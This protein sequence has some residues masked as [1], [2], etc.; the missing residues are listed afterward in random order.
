V[1]RQAKITFV[2]KIKH[3]ETGNKLI[4]SLLVFFLYPL[5]LVFGLLAMC[6]VGLLS[7]WQKLTNSKKELQEAEEMK[8]KITNESKHWSI[9]TMM[10]NVAI[11][12]QLA[13]SLPW[14]SGDYFYLKSSPE[15]EYL[16]NKLFGDWLLVASGGV[17]L[18]RW[19]DTENIN[20]DLAFIDL[21]TLKVTELKTDIPT[22]HWETEK[23]NENEI[24]FTFSTLKA[25]LVYI[26]D[27]T[28][29]LSKS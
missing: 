27:T 28:L 6:F 17:F 11:E 12:K 21:D 5:V 1:D 3:A 29:H 25:D 18:Q 24:K 19:N 20:C 13:G 15:I 9:F 14:D 7:F 8:F 4:D 16:N 2:K 10:P 23:V 26:I 22:K